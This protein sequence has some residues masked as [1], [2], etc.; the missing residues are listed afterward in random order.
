MHGAAR[1][2]RSKVQPSKPKIIQNNLAFLLNH[3]Y[4]LG[5]FYMIITSKSRTSFREGI[6]L[7]ELPGA[8]KSSR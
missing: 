6:W 7:I 4:I 1:E 8:H 3:D 2:Y 5:D